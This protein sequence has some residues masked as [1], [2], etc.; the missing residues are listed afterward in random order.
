MFM[1]N[2]YSLFYIFFICFALLSSTN[3]L[4]ARGGSG[5]PGKVETD[6]FRNYSNLTIFYRTF[7]PES[8]PKAAVVFMHA[9]AMHSGLYDEVGKYLSSKGY[10]VY[11][12]DLQGWG[13]SQG[14]RRNGFVESYDDYANDLGT[15]VQKIKKEHPGKKIFAAGEDIGATVAIYSEIRNNL[16]FDGLILSGTMFKPSPKFIFRGP[17][18]AT[19][20]GRGICRFGGDFVPNFVSVVPPKILVSMFFIEDKQTKKEVKRDPYFTKKFLPVKWAHA[21]LLSDK[22]LDDSLNAINEPILILHGEKDKTTPL[23][24][25]EEI[26]SEVSCPDKMLKVIQ[27]SGHCVLLDSQKDEALNMIGYWLDKRCDYDG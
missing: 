17:A 19:R 1:K 6:T 25:S 4:F 23:S 21:I 13:Q 16:H 27:G 5:S 10:V 12:P 20:W 14:Q 22:Y 3:L 9:T 7:L 15:L 26:S 18:F 2:R 24:S 8:E 11:C